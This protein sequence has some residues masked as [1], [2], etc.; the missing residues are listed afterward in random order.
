MSIDSAYAMLVPVCEHQVVAGHALE[1]VRQRQEAEA[2][3]RRPRTESPSRDAIDVR[4]DVVVR[5][6]HALR[7]ARRARRVDQRRESSGLH[8]DRARR[9]SAVAARVVVDRR[10]RVVSSAGERDDRR[11]RAESREGDD[12]PQRR[13]TR[14][15]SPRSSPPAPRS[16]RRSPPRPSRAGCTRPDRPA[17]SD[18]SARRS[19]PSVQARVVGDRPLGAILRED[20]DAVAGAHAELLEAERDAPHALGDAC[21]ARS[22]RSARS[23]LTCSASGL[24]YVATASKNSW[25]SVPGVEFR[26]PP[27]AIIGV[28]VGVETPSIR[29]R[30]VRGTVTALLARRSVTS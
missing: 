26:G 4:V 8:G 18:R 23:R 21:R 17:D 2:R 20:R 24:S 25:F 29:P 9:G 5:E 7:L 11:R 28:L 19:T 6:H 22:A 1:D 30:R 27:V 15:G 13:D 14:R 16:T 10:R 3:C 12:V